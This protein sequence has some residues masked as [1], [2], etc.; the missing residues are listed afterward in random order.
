MNGAMQDDE[1]WR[2]AFSAN[3]GL[4]F[5]APAADGG[6][7]FLS[8]DAGGG[9]GAGLADRVPSPA[10]TTHNDSNMAPL[11]PVPA[12][13]L[14]APV[15][16]H[17]QHQQQQPMLRVQVRGRGDERLPQSRRP[18]L[19]QQQQQQQRIMAAPAVNVPVL[20]AATAAVALP[21]AIPATNEPSSD[22]V[23]RRLD[24]LFFHM[25]TEAWHQPASPP[26][27]RPPR[28]MFTPFFF[29]FLPSRDR[30]T[31]CCLGYIYRSVFKSCVLQRCT[32]W[33]LAAAAV[34]HAR[35]A[36]NVKKS[37]G[38]VCQTRAVLVAGEYMR[39]YT[40]IDRERGNLRGSHACVQ[41]ALG[42]R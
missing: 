35:S 15:A 30:W 33:L 6:L 1:L 9:G 28:G 4:F 24:E 12:V 7:G 14:A 16:H 23:S 13:E 39:T 37:H 40:C 10:P 5:D 26:V 34:R 2:R 31:Y 41:L 42:R 22:Q 21:A 8:V 18:T 17:Q 32:F 29:F 27:C 38:C 20:G 11:A 3:A 19:P 36:R 25:C